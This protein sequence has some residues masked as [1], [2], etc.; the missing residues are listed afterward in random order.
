MTTPQDQVR[1]KEE[2]LL[3]QKLKNIPPDSYQELHYCQKAINYYINKQKLKNKKLDTPLSE[4]K[5]STFDICTLVFLSAWWRYKK[6]CLLSL[7]LSIVSAYL[8]T[9]NPK[10]TQV[11]ID[12]LV[13]MQRDQE[14]FYQFSYL[15]MLFVGVGIVNNLVQRLASETIFYVATKVEDSWLYTAINHYYELPMQWHT[16]NDCT[17]TASGIIE[18]GGSIWGVARCIYGQDILSNSL[19]LVVVMGTVI[20][21]YS[22][23]WWIFVLP[24]FVYAASAKRMSMFTTNFQEKVNIMARARHRIYYD[25]VNNIQEVKSFGKGT[26]ETI[27]FA[28]RQ[29]C[30]HLLEY[31]W[32]FVDNVKNLFL[33]CFKILS[34]GVL[35]Y[36]GFKLLMEDK[37]TVGTILMLRQYQQM[38]YSPLERM[39]GVYVSLERDC[40]RASNLFKVLLGN[41]N[42][43]DIDNAISLPALSNK[44]V[45]ENVSFFYSSAPQKMALN[46]INFE[47]PS[48]S[49]VALVGKSGAGKSTIA[50]LLLRFYDP[51]DGKILW[52]DIDIRNAKRSSLRK[53]ISVV[54]QQSSLF[55]RSI[56]DNIS[57][58]TDNSDM[59]DIIKAT[60]LAN[61]HDFIM[62]LP[63]QYDFV[64]GERGV[65][66]SGGQR[67]RISIARALLSNP[68]LIIFDEST[69]SLD[70]ESELAIQES[71]Q[72]LH[73]KLTQVIITHR[74]ST[75]IHADLIVVLHDGTVSGIGSHHELIKTN[76]IYS[77]F[78]ELQF[79]DDEKIL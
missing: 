24:M 43:K 26:F 25:G 42:L 71:I 35:F 66:L 14:F 56:K 78:Y 63:E 69:T 70:S 54:L 34:D 8:A 73:H 53:R 31:D 49:T 1:K 65:K 21:Y 48:G 18:G 51:V 9:L 41:D 64:V 57:Y 50:S 67:Q 13:N 59:E 32:V 33:T 15:L 29:S 74:L 3:F 37:I 2:N 77:K 20:Y 38:L 46:N 16:E 39:S 79:R 4:T 61:A 27:R 60:K 5:I 45:F 52:D 10:M 47:I 36:Y 30:Y 72:L 23:F 22:S 17:A 7:F 11:L 28:F 68:S 44:I 40:M 75:I 62:E 12:S 55:N 6:T 76:P 19:S 58:S